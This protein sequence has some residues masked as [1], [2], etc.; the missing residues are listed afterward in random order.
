MLWSLPVIR[1]VFAVLFHFAQIKLGLPY[2]LFTS[3]DRQKD[4]K[5]SI[6]N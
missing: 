4:E 2:E 1:L 3:H 6:I 5:T